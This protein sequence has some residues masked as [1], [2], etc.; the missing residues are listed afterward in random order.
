MYHSHNH[1]HSHIHTCIMMQIPLKT[2]YAYCT[3]KILLERSPWE[4]AIA[5]FPHHGKP[6]NI[7]SLKCDYWWYVRI[8][9]SC[10]DTATHGIDMSQT[11]IP[12]WITFKGKTTLQLIHAPLVSSTTSLKTHNMIWWIRHT[13]HPWHFHII[14]TW[15]SISHIDSG[16][17]LINITHYQDNTWSTSCEYINHLYQVYHN[18]HNNIY[19]TQ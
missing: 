6:N 14:V 2:L 12:N 9:L 11:E 7:F 13:I 3:N 15:W 4:H 10:N 18:I 8:I 17:M 19:K 1:L 16:H 5:K